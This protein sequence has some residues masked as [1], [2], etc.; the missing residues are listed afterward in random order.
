[1]IQGKSTRLVDFFLLRYRAHISVLRCRRW[2]DDG[3]QLA[4]DEA[5][6]LHVTAPY[7]FV[8]GGQ[9][10]EFA[11]SA[12]SPLI[13]PETGE[14]LGQVL[15]D[16]LPARMV[17]SISEETVLGDGGF[18]FLVSADFDSEFD[19]VIGPGY[20]PEDEP[21]SITDLILKY[22]K[23]CD[24]D[25]CKSNVDAFVE[26]I[27]EMKNGSI[28]NA[29]LYRVDEN[30]KVETLLLSFAPVT[31]P[32]FRPVDSSD[33][34]R[35]LEASEYTIYS[36]ALVE[37]ENGIL[38]AFEPIRDVTDQQVARAI[39]ILSTLLIFAT[40]LIVFISLRLTESIAEPMVYLLEIIRSIRYVFAFGKFY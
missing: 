29:T 10:I 2:Y 23:L 20:F 28:G 7:E 4:L 6:Y 9:R 14:H 17:R 16:F 39:G 35:G 32:S 37:S 5:R 34:S 24:S 25:R 40:I 33:F 30:E 22:D 21:I 31:V 13:D 15:L 36:L 3:R 12:T 27:K 8:T 11:Q 26:V 19:T 1:M 38:E 18:P